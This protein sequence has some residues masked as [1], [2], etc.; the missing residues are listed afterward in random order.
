[1]AD[2]DGDGSIDEKEFIIVMNA[3]SSKGD[4]SAPQSNTK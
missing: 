2:K 4:S 3:G 1:M